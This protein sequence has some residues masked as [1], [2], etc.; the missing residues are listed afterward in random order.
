M[1][2]DVQQ[3]KAIAKG[4]HAESGLAIPLPGAPRTS[5]ASVSSL[6]ALQ[7]LFKDGEHLCMVPP[8]QPEALVAAVSSLRADPARAEALAAAG[9]QRVRER[10]TWAAHAAHLA[11]LF[12]TLRG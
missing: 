1:L 9:C 12:R 10:H 8:E 5:V 7:Q 3:A 2:G 11:E 4:V 6:Q